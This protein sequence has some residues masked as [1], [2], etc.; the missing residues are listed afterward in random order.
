MVDREREERKRE[1]E[2]RMKKLETRICM[3]ICALVE[4]R[5]KREK[6]RIGEKEREEVEL[7]YYRAP[8]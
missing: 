5:T 4:A 1:R 8:S 6:D 2:N 7:C 3:R